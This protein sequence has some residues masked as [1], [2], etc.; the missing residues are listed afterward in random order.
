LIYDVVIA[1]AGPVGLFLANVASGSGSGSRPD[2]ATA[3]RAETLDHCKWLPQ[4]GRPYVAVAL[5]STNS[6]VK[7]AEVV[8]SFRN[9]SIIVHYSRT[10]PNCHQLIN[11]SYVGQRTDA[12][13]LS[14]VYV[15]QPSSMVS[16]ISAGVNFKT[17]P[18]LALRGTDFPKSRRGD[19]HRQRL[20]LETLDGKVIE[21]RDNPRGAFIGRKAETPWDKLHVAYFSSYALWTYFSSPFLYTLPGFDTE[22]ITPWH[23]N[24]ETWRRLKVIFPNTVA[25]HVKEQVTYFGPDGLM[26]RHDYTVEILGGATG[27]NRLGV[28]LSSPAATGEKSMYVPCPTS[29][30][31][32]ASTSCQP[33]RRSSNRDRCAA[34]SR[35]L[36]AP[37]A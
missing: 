23:E 7:Y 8:T 17:A 14:Q 29:V 28:S 37:A 15:T 1:G 16:A 34:S 3:G 36:C 21:S 22:E 12:P 2:R 32:D 20:T 35:A 10:C 9:F 19:R 5:A 4:R 13:V 24:G 27:A 18:D 26:R 33:S 6:P 25:G 30:V 11:R 31:H